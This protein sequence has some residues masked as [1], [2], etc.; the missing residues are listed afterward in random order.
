MNV[1][2]KH[3]REQHGTQKASAIISVWRSFIAALED[4]LESYKNCREAVKHPAR[5]LQK[6]ERLKIAG[7][8]RYTGCQS[9]GALPRSH[10]RF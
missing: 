7:Y 3:A 5:I 2:D 10:V 8:D 4:C 6:T 9:A 1:F